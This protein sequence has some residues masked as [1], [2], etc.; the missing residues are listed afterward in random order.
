MRITFYFCCIPL[1]L[2]VVLLTIYQDD[3]LA[4]YYWGCL[5]SERKNADMA[6]KRV[7][8][9]ADCGKAGLD[10]ALEDV[11][12]FGGESKGWYAAVIRSH[13]MQEVAVRHLEGIAADTENR[14]RQIGAAL[15]LVSLEKS[16]ANLYSALISVSDPGGPEVRVG[17]QRLCAYWDSDSRDAVEAFLVKDND[18]RLSISPAMFRRFVTEHPPF[19][20]CNGIGEPP[21][22]EFPR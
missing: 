16:V 12:I 1:V 13:P 9:L 8:E 2:A 20:E 18:E 17:R 22:A 5:V 4:R 6:W 3:L 7:F 14:G 21:P 19:G 11:D 10:C 15:L